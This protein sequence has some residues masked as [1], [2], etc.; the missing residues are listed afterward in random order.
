MSEEKK[1]KIIGSRL[2]LGDKVKDVVTGFTGILIA[3]HKWLHGCRRVTIQPQ[4]LKDGK[5]VEAQSFDDQQCELVEAG[6][7]PT[8]AATGGPQDES[9]VRPPVPRQ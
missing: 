7:V 8:T 6:V 1:E 3:E 4:E 9:R 2:Q 5:P